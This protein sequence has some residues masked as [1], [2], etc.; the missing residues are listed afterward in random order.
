MPRLAPRKR[1]IVFAT[2]MTTLPIVLLALLLL[3]PTTVSARSLDIYFIDVEGGQ[4]TL[5]VTP[6][7]KSLL[8]DA[9][10]ARDSRDPD[11]ILAALRDAGLERLDFLMITHFH[12]DHV[13]G[14]P[15]LATRIPI[16]TFIDYGDPLGTTYG[17]D[18]MTQRNFEL[19]E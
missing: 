15:E 18:R 10:Y 7:G 9:G 11:R 17:A 13:G 8:I 6:A 1:V 4:A 2:P 14:V 19:Y 12:S 16:G 5:V 3:T